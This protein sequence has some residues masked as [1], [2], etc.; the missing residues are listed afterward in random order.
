[1]MLKGSNL[2]D[3]IVRERLDH[4]LNKVGP[5]YREATLDNYVVSTNEQKAMIEKLRAYA[6][7]LP[8]EVKGGNGILLFGPSGTGKDH[9][10]IAIA[11]V[12]IERGCDLR[13]VNGV[14][15]HA[16]VRAAIQRDQ[17]DVD[18]LKRYCS[19]RV[20]LISD[21]APVSGALTDFQAATLYRLV[22]SRYR[23]MLPIWA[24]LNAA[25]PAE[26]RARLGA[27]I[28]DRLRD[29][30]LAIECKWPSHRRARE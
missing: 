19:A 30:A 25:D 4:F 24:S 27:A 8:A 7:D 13:W 9:A 3:Q 2:M 15:L 6:S 1:M 17:S 12:A 10:L 11:R 5:R 26:A 21:I 16:E 28:V 18:F 20:L 29:G 23:R 22:D 14:D